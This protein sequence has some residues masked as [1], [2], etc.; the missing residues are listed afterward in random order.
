MAKLDKFKAASLFTTHN[1]SGLSDI[2]VGSNLADQR[3][4]YNSV[5]TLSTFR[6]VLP[7]FTTILMVCSNQLS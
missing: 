6:V 7:L 3:R 4:S 2:S 5:Q 1:P